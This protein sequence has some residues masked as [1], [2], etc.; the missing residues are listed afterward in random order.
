MEFDSSATGCIR[1]KGV[2]MK[3]IVLEI[4][5]GEAAVLREDGVVAHARTAAGV[6]E[7]IEV[8][9]IIPVHEK[10]GKVLK[11]RKGTRR[12]RLAV[13]MAALAAAALL[14]VTG[15]GAYQYTTVQAA[16][17]VS[18]EDWYGFSVDYIVNRRGQVIEIDVYGQDASRITEEM[19][20][21]GFARCTLSEAIEITGQSIERQD[22]ADTDAKSS[23]PGGAADETGTAAQDNAADGIGTAAQ[24]EAANGT[25][26][27]TRGDA[28]DETG[29]AAQDDAA[30]ETGTATRGDAADGTGTAAQDD[31]AGKR[32]LAFSV[33]ALN[34][35]QQERLTREVEEWITGNF[36]DL[37]EN[38]RPEIL[39]GSM[40][41]HEKAREEGIGTAAFLRSRLEKERETAS[42]LP[43]ENDRPETREKDAGQ[44][45]QDD[46]SKTREKDAGQPSQDDRPETMEKNVGQ[47]T[48]DGLPETR[49]KDAGQPSQDDRPETTEK[50]AG[51]PTQDGLPETRE[52]DAG[53][54]SQDG[55]SETT[56]K[57]A[58]QSS[59]DGRSETL[60][61]DAGQPSQNGT[62]E[63]R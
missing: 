42:P 3:A 60:E 43:Q 51:Q 12:F 28:A 31:A 57:D 55:R 19:G 38:E 11:G 16:A 15:V 46:S 27:A 9:D 49:E 52:K 34:R 63:T 41:D 18:M 7:T 48:Q 54:P 4:R 8:E 39:E 50:D 62:P 53:Q 6:G 23:V 25:G 21:D 35:R 45:T 33:T 29:T 14:A 26:T 47:P 61:K 17:C 30:D 44:P 5:D 20:K 58:G 37:D 1:G 13:R 24:G 36:P 10:S 40:E 32:P 2:T 56:E 22:A 59:Q